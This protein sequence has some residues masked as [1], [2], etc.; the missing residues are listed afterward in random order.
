L[1]VQ[2]GDLKGYRE[3]RLRI[4]REYGN[5]SDPVTCERLSKDCLFVPPEDGQLEVLVK[6]TDRAVAAG[7]SHR[8]YPYF[9][10]AKGLAEYRRSRYS[11]AVDWLQKALL[12]TNDSHRTV[13]TFA[14]LAMAQQR[15]GQNDE[16]KKT[17]EQ[18]VA[19]AKARLPQP[20]KGRLMKFGTIGLSHTYCSAKRPT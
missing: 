17:L 9:A 7:P 20:S 19:L 16:A 11:E 14:T 15:L 18:G 1:L 12:Q 5:E 10:F 13:M 6:M 8:S 3:L 4:L 2:N